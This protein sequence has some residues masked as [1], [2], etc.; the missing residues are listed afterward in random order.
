MH[1]CID[2]GAHCDCDG[3]DHGQ[4]TPEDCTGCQCA[5]CLEFC[6]NCKCYDGDF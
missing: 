3:E 4:D 1:D 6:C 5:M 2:C